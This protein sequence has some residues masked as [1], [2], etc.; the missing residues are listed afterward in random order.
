MD[1]IGFIGKEKDA[2]SNLGDFGVRKYEDFS[3]RFTSP[4]PLWEKYYGWSPYHYCRNNPVSR[5]DPNGNDE[6]YI[7]SKGTAEGEEQ[8]KYITR[9]TGKADFVG[10]TYQIGTTDNVWHAGK[11]VSSDKYNNII[12]DIANNIYEKGPSK[13]DLKSNYGIEI[14]K[15]SDNFKDLLD[16][17]VK[18]QMFKR[19][20]DKTFGDGT[21]NPF[22]SEAIDNNEELF[23]GI[24]FKPSHSSFF[25][26]MLK[27]AGI[28]GSILYPAGAVVDLL[29]SKRTQNDKHLQLTK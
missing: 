14:D 19:S 29:L 8:K 12:T 28:K 18:N 11:W 1:R 5:V 16:N 15:L 13:I 22:F 9:T 23:I 7:Q 3:G 20:Y 4:D 27:K 24:G 25:G 2:E 21:P 17:E 10:G 6:I 26:S